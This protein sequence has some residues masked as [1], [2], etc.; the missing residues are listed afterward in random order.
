MSTTR[1]VAAIALASLALAVTATAGESWT[2]ASGEVRVRCRLTVGGSFD[3]VTSQISGPSGWRTPA[4]PGLSGRFASGHR[5]SPNRRATRPARSVQSQPHDSQLWR[6]GL[7]VP[8]SSEEPLCYTATGGGAPG[9]Q[10]A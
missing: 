3:A 4:L 7:F 2:I 8:G 6:Y 1:R 10:G 5:G 9:R